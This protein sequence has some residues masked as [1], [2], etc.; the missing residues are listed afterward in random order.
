MLGP[1]E[2]FSTGCYL[3]ACVLMYNRLFSFGNCTHLCE[4]Y[5]VILFLRKASCSLFIQASSPLQVK[6]A[7]GELERLG[8]LHFSTMIFYICPYNFVLGP[9]IIIHI[10][11]IINLLVLVSI[12]CSFTFHWIGNCFWAYVTFVKHTEHK[13]FVGMLPKNVTDAEVSDLFSQY[14]SIKDL[15]ILRG[16]QQ[17]SKGIAILYL[18]FFW[19]GVFD[20]CSQA[21]RFMLFS[22]CCIDY[23]GCAFLKYETKEQALSAI[24]A[25]NGKHKMEVCVIYQ[26]FLIF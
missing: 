10:V 3:S 21:R 5:T 17:T 22:V 1:Y 7:D 6:Y 16:S 15:Q 4:C 9:Y 18:N 8:E 11:S 13:L 26:S 20:W 23:V 19:V 12:L 2:Q 24:E 25:L 14:G